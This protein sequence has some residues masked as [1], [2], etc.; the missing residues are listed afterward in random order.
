[1]RHAARSMAAWEGFAAA[2]EVMRT[3]L[4]YKRRH[5]G[6]SVL[7]TNARNRSSETSG[8]EVVPMMRTAEPWHGNGF[9]LRR[10][11]FR[12]ISAVFR[13]LAQSM[14]RTLTEQT[15]YR[16]RKEY[17]GPKVD[18]AKRLKDLERVRGQSLVYP[19]R[20]S[21]KLGELTWR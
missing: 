12:H 10:C 17:G 2:T 21:R 15:L 14:M 18:Q 1:M 9:G 5:S 20:G 11:A 4:G 6:E 19:S 8:R 16:W 13:L 3:H 7:S